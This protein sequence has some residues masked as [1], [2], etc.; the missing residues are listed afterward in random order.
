MTLATVPEFA[1]SKIPSLGPFNLY[2]NNGMENKEKKTKE[3]RSKTTKNR[4][5][6]RKDPP[7]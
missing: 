6:T 7:K 5:G 2:G 1:G 4:A 3:L